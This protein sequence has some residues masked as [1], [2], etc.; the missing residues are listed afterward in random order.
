M[1][2]KCCSLIY[3]VRLNVHSMYMTKIMYPLFGQ[4]GPIEIQDLFLQGVL[5]KTAA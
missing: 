5:V 1:F 3:A 4:E 2:T